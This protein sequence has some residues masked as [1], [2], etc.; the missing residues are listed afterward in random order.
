MKKFLPIIEK[1]A[2]F[3]GLERSEV[4]A[5]LGCLSVT[6]AHF[7]KDDFLLRWGDRAEALGL[8]LSGRALIIKEDF[9]GN[10]NILAQAGPGE[11][12]AEAYACTPGAALGVSVIAAEATEVIF[13]NAGRVLTSCGNACEFHA[14]LIRNLVSALAGKNLQLNRKLSHLTQRSTRD[15][16]LS[17]LSG[18][19]QAAASP[20]F[21]LPFDRQQLADY[22]SVDRSAMCSELGR[23][24]DQGLLAYEKRH[25]TL[26]APAEDNSR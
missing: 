7:A 9:W 19:A 25:I 14:R 15:K 16:L 4:E 20:S 10:R 17:Y 12:F 23:M 13:M 8:V 6:R 18:Q 5:M 11:L 24:R 21:E 3:S 2:L 22:L 26:L 1:S